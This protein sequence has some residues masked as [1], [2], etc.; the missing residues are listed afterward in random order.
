[1]VFCGANKVKFLLIVLFQDYGKESQALDVLNEY[2]KS[3]K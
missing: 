3:K 2:F 1:M